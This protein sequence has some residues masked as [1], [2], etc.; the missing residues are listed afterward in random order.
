M[1]C[2]HAKYWHRLQTCCGKSIPFYV[3]SLFHSFFC[4]QQRFQAPHLLSV[5]Y[6]TLAMQSELKVSIL[7]N[8]GSL[9]RN[10]IA[11]IIPVYSS[12][13]CLQGYSWYVQFMLSFCHVSLWIHFQ[14]SGHYA[15]GINESKP[16]PL[17]VH[18]AL[19]L[20][21]LLYLLLPDL[22]LNS[23]RV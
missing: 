17:L 10:S 15:S 20:H 18:Q 21:L 2:D 22:H 4:P 13:F 5:Q 1:K 7:S 9:V 14:F 12:A 23:K 6:L 11:S 8:G 19:T 16:V 3:V